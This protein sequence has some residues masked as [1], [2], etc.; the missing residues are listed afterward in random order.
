VNTGYLLW[1]AAL[2]AVAGGVLLW[3]AIGSVP[4]IPTDPA[5]DDPGGSGAE[6][7][8]GPGTPVRRPGVASEP[9]AEDRF[10]EPA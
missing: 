7:P 5:T 6:G 1:F 2:V 9:A 4:D 3:L 8:L 10:A